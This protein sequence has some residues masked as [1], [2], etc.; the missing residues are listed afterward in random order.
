MD[1][2]IIYEDQSIIV[3]EKPPTVPSQVD[4]T[5]DKDMVTLLNEHLLGQKVSNP[6]IGIIHRLDRPVGGVMV[7]SKTKE[8]NANLS[9]QVQDKK[10]KKSYLAVVCGVPSQKHQ[11]LVDLLWKNERLNMSKVVCKGTNN[12]K[13]A[14]LEYDLL[15][16]INDDQFGKLSLL[17]VDLQTGRHHQIRVQLS[18]AGLPLWG[19]TK[20]N[21]SFMKTHDWSQIALWAESLE[22][23]HPSTA[24]RCRYQSKPTEYP[25][26]SFDI[27]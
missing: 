4:K 3:V 17:R 5:G 16:S 24:K 19:D 2:N 10:L 18:N 23:G 14:I 15:A 26:L 6:T 9:K 11:K 20:Y 25:F 22:F 12:A 1:L 7:F 27:Q 8:A 13:E 21:P